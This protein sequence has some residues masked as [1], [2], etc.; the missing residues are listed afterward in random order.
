MLAVICRPQGPSWL[1]PTAVV[2][3]DK[4]EINPGMGSEGMHFGGADKSATGHGSTVEWE[5]ERES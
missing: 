4:R 1:R 5:G 3:E 2:T